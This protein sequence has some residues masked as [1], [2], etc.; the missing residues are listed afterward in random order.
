MSP[1][2]LEATPVNAK[3]SQAKRTVTFNRAA[4]CGYLISLS[5]GYL[6]GLYIATQLF[7]SHGQ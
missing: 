7:L 4:L 2:H 5:V 1:K 6:L 3:R